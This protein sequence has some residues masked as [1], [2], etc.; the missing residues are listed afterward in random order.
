MKKFDFKNDL[1]AMVSFCFYRCVLNDPVSFGDTF[2][3]SFKMH[4]RKVVICIGLLILLPFIIFFGGIF[5]V[6]QVFKDSMKVQS[7]TSYCFYL[8]EGEKPKKWNCY[9]KF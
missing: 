5:S 2:R 9:K 7:W 4:P 6:N 8:Q 1:K 3:W